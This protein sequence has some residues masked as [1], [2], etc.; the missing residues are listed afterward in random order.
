MTP[1]SPTRELTRR[2]A[3][4]GLA[5]ALSS[6]ALAGLRSE[7]DFDVLIVGAGADRPVLL[8]PVV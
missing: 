1:A 4:A 6:P 7:P 5:S 8:P 2:S 3:V